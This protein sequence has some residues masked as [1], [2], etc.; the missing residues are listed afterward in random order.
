MEFT[1]DRRL[2]LLRDDQPGDPSA[3]QSHLSD[4]DATPRWAHDGELAGRL[5]VPALREAPELL[6]QLTLS[7][8]AN[9]SA[10]LT[11]EHQA[12][13]RHYVEVLNT[14]RRQHGLNIKITDHTDAVGTETHNTTLGQ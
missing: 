5:T 11:T 13:I 10:T 1:M 2:R 12:N 7:G 6:G 3:L 9:D 8:F 4:P 14:L